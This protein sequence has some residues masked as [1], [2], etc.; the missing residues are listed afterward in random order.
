MKG[1]VGILR[2]TGLV[3][4]VDTAYSSVFAV[5]TAETDL[6]LAVSTRI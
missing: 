5:S 3:M 6:C 4:T 2:H 1:F